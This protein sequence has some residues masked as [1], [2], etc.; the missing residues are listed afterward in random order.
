MLR[1]LGGTRTDCG[2]TRAADRR[3]RDRAPARPAPRLD[4]GRAGHPRA[5]LARPRRRSSRCC[6][7]EEG[8]TRRARAARHPAAG[9][10]SG[11]RRR[12]FALRKVA[13]E[14]VGELDRRADRS[15]PGLR[16]PPAPGARVLGL[17]LA[18]RRRRP[19]ARPRRPAL[20]GPL[21]VRRVAG[22][23]RSRRTR[24]SGSTAS[25][26]SRWCC[27]RWRSAARSGR[28]AGCSTSSTCRTQSSF[29]DEFVRDRAGQSLAHVFTLLSLVLPRGAAADRVS[30]PAYRR[31]EPAGHGARVSRRRAAAADPR[32]AVAVPRGSAG[33]QPRPRAPRDE[34]LA[35]LLRSNQSIMLNLEELRRRAASDRRRR[36]DR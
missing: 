1:T 3:H 21:P 31:S 15:E 24:A 22:R 6:A 4:P 14:R 36:R 9:V 27:A 20:R 19:A 26:S 34:I 25:A 16:R 32:A 35:D 33:R 7:R 13:E 11:R 30:R 28:A 17:R 23:D 10:G 5:A 18:A 8:L 12:V 29:V 2:L